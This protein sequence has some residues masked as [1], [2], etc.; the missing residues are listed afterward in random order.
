MKI[1]IKGLLTRID[2]TPLQNDHSLTRY[3]KEEAVRWECILGT[4]ECKNFVAFLHNA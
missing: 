3:L 4:S 2:R 1:A